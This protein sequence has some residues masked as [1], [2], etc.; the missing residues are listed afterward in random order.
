MT[1]YAIIV[2]GGTGSRFGSSVP[3]QFLDLGGKPVLC[4]TL[5]A[6]RDVIPLSR[7][8]TVVSG[9]MTTFWKELCDTAG[10]DP[11]PIAIGGD[12]RWESVK[13]GLEALGDI[14]ADDIVLVHD[15]ARPLAGPE[16]ICA[17]AGALQSTDADG[18]IPAMPLTDS[19]RRISADG[20]S[21]DAVDRSRYRSVQ[22]PQAFPA[23]KLAQAFAIPYRPEFTDEA[24][25]MAAAG[26]TDI[27]LVPGQERNLKITRPV[28]IAI[29]EFF[30]NNGC[31]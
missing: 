30:L 5:Q 6:F 20:V 28:D 31:K 21:S 2:A 11:G 23:G 15:G 7:I 19:I 29:A 24:S 4:H 14:D 9:A 10:I 16:F 17:I 26:Y 1:I 8:V 12:T 25:M 13:N 27:R 18:V 3:K 22:T